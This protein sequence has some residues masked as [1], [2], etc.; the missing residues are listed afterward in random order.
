MTEAEAIKFLQRQRRHMVSTRQLSA[1]EVISRFRSQS[2]AMVSVGLMF[3]L[4]ALVNISKVQSKYWLY[5]R[6]FELV[7]GLN[8]IG[9]AAWRFIR[10]RQACR[11]LNCTAGSEKQF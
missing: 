5:L 1:G 7:I 8:M 6:I 9:L 2:L 10:L 11:A 4:F 3:I